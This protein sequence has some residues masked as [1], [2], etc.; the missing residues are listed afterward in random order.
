MMYNDK[1]VYKVVIWVLFWGYFMK[2]EGSFNNVLYIL[3]TAIICHL[4]ISSLW[5]AGE[6]DFN[7]WQLK[8]WCPQQTVCE[9][10]CTPQMVLMTV[11]H[12]AW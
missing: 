3:P 11:W 6:K 12:H 8:S 2:R 5:T 9:K 1:L 4:G 10:T 7:C